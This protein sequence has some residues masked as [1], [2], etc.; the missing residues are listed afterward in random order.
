MSD[1]SLS[2]VIPCFN[3]V[4]NIPIFLERVVE[5]VDHLPE[6][7][8]LIFVDG[9]S[10]D[11]TVY[12]TKESIN[13]YSLNSFVRI[14]SGSQHQTGYGADIIKGLNECTGKF[15]AWTHADLQTDFADVLKGYKNLLEVNE[16]DECLVKGRRVG[17]PIFDNIFTFGMQILTLL[18]LRKNIS[19]I[20]AQPKIFKK[21]FYE[22]YIKNGAPNDFSL[23]LYLLY[24]AKKNKVKILSF[25]VHFGTRFSG[26]PKGGGGGIVPKI[27]LVMRTFNY[28]KSLRAYVSK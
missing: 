10:T 9:G 12:V 28:M 11:N 22:R 1:R 17:R 21:V 8:E 15:L 13:H 7:F 14:V 19:D 18:M 6:E 20:N 27:R 26:E 16:C 3:E 25:P 24:Q 4:E 23:D 5:L 2:V